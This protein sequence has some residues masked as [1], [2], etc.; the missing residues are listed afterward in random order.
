MEIK[1]SPKADLERN[2]SIFLM[3]GLAVALG[4]VW[5][6]FEW[7]QPQDKVDEIKYAMDNEIEEEAI[8]TTENV[9]PPPPPPP[10]PPKQ[11]VAD[12]IEVTTEKLDVKEEIQVEAEADVE[13]EV[14]VQEIKEEE[15]VIEEKTVFVRVEKMPEFPGGIKALLGYIG[16]HMKY[17]QIAADNGIQGRVYLKFVVEKDGSVGEV[18][19]LRSPDKLL[20]KEAVRVVKTIPKFRPGMQRGKAVRVWYQL[21]VTFRL[22]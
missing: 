5:A 19:V 1:K 12:V 17:P 20:E 18:V 21:P 13:E 6:M 7:S 9:P 2:R 8:I 11:Q 22:Q 15:E 16:K 3:F 4:F 10:P 14:E